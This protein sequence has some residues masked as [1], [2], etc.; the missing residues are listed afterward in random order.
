ME[1]DH[2]HFVG[3]GVSW[4]E[5]AASWEPSLMPGGDAAVCEQLSR[6]NAILPTYGFPDA[7]A[8]HRDRVSRRIANAH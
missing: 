3:M 1:D 4:G 7:T 6:N 5:Q 2:I 8:Q